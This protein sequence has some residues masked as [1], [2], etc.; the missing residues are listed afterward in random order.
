MKA[1]WR[2]RDFEKH[3]HPP[4]E[5]YF[6]FKE[7]TLPDGNVIARIEQFTTNERCFYANTANDRSGCLSN[8]DWARQWCETATGNKV[9]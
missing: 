8:Y 4:K 2:D 7:L 3:P 6:T 1:E 5:D 9:N